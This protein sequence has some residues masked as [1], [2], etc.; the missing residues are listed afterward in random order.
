MTLRLNTDAAGYW[1]LLNNYIDSGPFH[2]PRLSDSESV[3][4]FL[5]FMFDAC[6]KQRLEVIPHVWLI[7]TGAAPDGIMMLSLCFCNPD[8]VL[9]HFVDLVLGVIGLGLCVRGHGAGK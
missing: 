2:P 8:L 1:F 9:N 7:L 6:Q 3:P 4:R 5:V